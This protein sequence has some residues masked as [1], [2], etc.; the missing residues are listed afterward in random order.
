MRF[1]ECFRDVC[2]PYCGANVS[3]CMEGF[4]ETQEGY[5]EEFHC[6]CGAR[7]NVVLYVETPADEDNIQ[8]C[9]ENYAEYWKSAS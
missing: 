4:E 8:E 2:C 3:F 9:R 1:I 7:F 5:S 6:H